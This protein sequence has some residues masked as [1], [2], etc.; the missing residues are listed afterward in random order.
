MRIFLFLLTL[1][2]AS[3]VFAQNGNSVLP[4]T[5]DQPRPLAL[6]PAPVN[7]TV[8]TGQFTL[9]SAIVIEA[10]D[11]KGIDPVL[12]ELKTQLSLP[13]GYTVTVTTQPKTDATIR[14]VLNKTPETTLGSEGYYLSVT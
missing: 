9:P 7:L 4:M 1:L 3:T 10:Q 13:T 12:N 2:A 14:L 6:I 8:N 11:Q 5:A